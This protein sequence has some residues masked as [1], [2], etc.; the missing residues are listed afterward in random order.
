MAK[1]M[2]SFKIN[3][4]KHIIILYTNV[5]QP[6]NEKFLIEFYLKNGYT[7]MTET[8]KKGK[9]V[10]EMRDELAVDEKAL[11]EFNQAYTDKTKGFHAA[12]KIY[13]NWKKNN[14]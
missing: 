9:T 10:G 2:Q 12:C 8:K 7:P 6:E 3:E 1:K 5:E 14:K 13:T 11:K 4:D